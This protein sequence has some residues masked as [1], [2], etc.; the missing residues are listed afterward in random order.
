MAVRLTGII[1][2]EEYNKKSGDMNWGY[3]RFHV[4]VLSI[5]ELFFFSF[6]RFCWNTETASN[7]FT[8]IGNQDKCSW[9]F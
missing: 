6:F 8:G 1:T 2:A 9:L 4:T 5:N 3:H 7:D